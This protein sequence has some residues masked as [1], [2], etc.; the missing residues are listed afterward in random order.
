MSAETFLLEKIMK[1]FSQLNE[2]TLK[3]FGG[4]LVDDTD[5]SGII[6]VKSFNHCLKM[7]YIF[8]PKIRVTSSLVKFADSI[9]GLS[10]VQANQAFHKSWKI[11]KESSIEELV[12][13][14]ILHYFS[15]YGFEYFGVYDEKSVYMPFEDL[16]VPELDGGLYLRIVRAMSKQEILDGVFTLAGGIALSKETIENIFSV[17]VELDIDSSILEKINN[18]E[19]KA[20]LYEY[21]D[22]YPTDAEE[23]FR[24][25]IYRVTGE[26]LVIKN[27][28]LIEKIKSS[29]KSDILDYLLSF[30]PDDMGKI[31][32]RYK[33]LFLALK[34]ISKNKYYFNRIRRD[35]VRIHAPKAKDYLL[36]ITSDIK[37]NTF[38]KREF[39]YAL[40]KASPFRKIRVLYGLQN[41]L[42]S[43]GNN[44]APKVYRVR[45]GKAWMTRNGVDRF[46]DKKMVMLDWAY[47]VTVDSIVEDMR[48]NVGGKTFVIPSNVEYAMP[49]SEKQFFGNF[50]LN[51]YVELEKDVVVGI[52]WVNRGEG[53]YANRVDID[54]SLM[55]IDGKTGW[56]AR[57]RNDNSTILFSGDV[58]DAPLPNGASEILYIANTKNSIPVDATINVN[59]Y[60]YSRGGENANSVS[61]FVANHRP[62][63]MEKNYVVNPN[64]IVMKE[65]FTLENA[66]HTIGY[67]TNVDGKIRVYFSPMSFGNSITARGGEKED[68]AREY[69]K[70]S[71]LSAF[72]LRSFIEMAGG[73]VYSE[74]P[75][76]ASVDVV[77]FSPNVITKESF[78]S[79]FGKSK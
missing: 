9:F 18:R 13:H 65:K 15:T 41:M 52:H 10:G 56:D 1:S 53:G 31:F 11:V 57:Y 36:N 72:P 30:A 61:F 79:L 8:D 71:C 76:D 35:A 27:K 19:L 7:G 22:I 24:Y 2:A 6:D 50:P 33:P 23:F 47:V 34:K 62:K 66:Q 78:I 16:D 3:L 48:V 70:Q 38:D 42:D 59:D 75:G 14:Q 12:A 5:Q 74:H 37:N 46:N 39:L 64:D 32:L 58:T 44:E 67:I 21:F 17:I 77:D 73:T 54:L 55:S 45:N 69:F 51:T 49:Q 43:V 29:N 25:L 63:N 60:T 68:I 40:S 28:Y 20:A 4:V 26:T